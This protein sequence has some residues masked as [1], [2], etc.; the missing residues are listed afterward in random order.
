MHQSYCHFQFHIRFEWDWENQFSLYKTLN[1]WSP[2]VVLMYM[3]TNITVLTLCVCAVHV[4]QSFMVNE[5]FDFNMVH[6]VAKI[7]SLVHWTWLLPVSEFGGNFG[8]F[9]FILGHILGYF[10]MFSGSCKNI[11][12]FR[13][14]SELLLPRDWHWKWFEWEFWRHHTSST[15]L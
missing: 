5:R 4:P 8:I 10:L 9:E 6:V 1:K 3:Y 12:T 13:L 7:K 2:H 14:I 15:S 11:F